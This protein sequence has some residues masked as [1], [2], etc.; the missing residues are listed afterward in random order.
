[1]T[2]LI[3][4]SVTWQTLRTDIM[5]CIGLLPTGNVVGAPARFTIETFGA[6]KGDVE[7]VVLNPKGVAEKVC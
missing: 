3:Y 4:S 1:M 2:R 7:V 5:S 6:G